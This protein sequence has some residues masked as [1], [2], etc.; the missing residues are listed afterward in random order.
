[1]AQAWKKRG[2]RLDYP[3]SHRERAGAR[4]RRHSAVSGAASDGAG[5]GY[6]A[7]SA[8]AL[9]KIHAL[10]EAGD[11]PGAID[12]YHTTARTLF[13]WPSQLDLYS[14]IKALH[15]R[16]Y[17]AES[18][19]LM[20][21]HC[22]CYPEDSTKVVLEL[23]QILIT[24]V[25]RPAAALRVLERS[26]PASLPLDLEQTRQRLCSRRNGCAKPVQLN[27]K[28]MTDPSFDEK[29]TER[30]VRTTAGVLLYLARP[31]QRHCRV[32]ATHRPHT[33]YGGLH[34]PYKW[35]TSARVRYSRDKYTS[36]PQWP[37]IDRSRLGKGT[38]AVTAPHHRTYVSYPYGRP[39]E[40]KRPV[41][42]DTS[43]IFWH[44]RT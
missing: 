8:Q 29:G 26:L 30:V 35:V 33:V 20:R 7:Q 1:M 13:N 22:R 31:R 42:G 16:G 3:K 21:D 11:I 25:E 34:P 36:F 17:E 5:Q 4:D 12:V 14:M 28:G 19:P 15:A 39:A 24:K 41:N 38:P 9:G 27:W 10:I 6:E 23:A 44:E 18:V 37:L 43:A 2:A 40:F 32:G